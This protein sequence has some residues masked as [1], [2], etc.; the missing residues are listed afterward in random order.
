MTRDAVK[1]HDRARRADRE[2]HSVVDPCSVYFINH[3]IG[4]YSVI[5]PSPDSHGARFFGRPFR[6]NRSSSCA[7]RSEARASAGGRS[8]SISGQ[9]VIDGQMTSRPI[10]QIGGRH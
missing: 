10:S 4:I 7:G 9:P 8:P 2:Q 3:P 6:L 1:L 5:L